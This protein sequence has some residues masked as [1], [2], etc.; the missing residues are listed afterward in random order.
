[1]F[2][3][4]DTLREPETQ[5]V[6]LREPETQLGT[7]REPETQLGTLREPETQ[8]G[9]RGERE[10]ERDNGYPRG[11]LQSVGSRQYPQYTAAASMYVT[12]CLDY[13]FICKVTNKHIR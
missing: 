7:L 2:N 5:L 9:Q 12:G 8:L 1:V 11:L 3:T 10:I 13:D 4:R 6:A